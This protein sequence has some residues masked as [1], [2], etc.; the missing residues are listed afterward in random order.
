MKTNGVISGKL[1]NLDR[2]LSRLKSLAPLDSERLEDWILH[3]AVERNLQV[4][5][6]IVIDICHRLHSLSG[7]SPAA[8]AREAVEGC[9]ELGVLETTETLS[10]MIGFRNLVVHR[11]E[12]ID[13]NILIDVVNNHLEDFELFRKKVLNYVDS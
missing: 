11:Y 12:Y 7:K 13:T 8:N 1:K 9:V 6:E 5:V 10:R 3:G 4:A 2:I